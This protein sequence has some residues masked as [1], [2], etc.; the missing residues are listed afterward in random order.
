[1]NDLV[2]LAGGMATRLNNITQN[3]PKSLIEI[4]GKPF[5]DYQMELFK[6]KGIQNVIV[7]VGHFGEMIE[8]HVGDGSRFGL[9][10]KYSYDGTT[11][12]G[13]GG[14][15]RKALPLLNDAFFVMYGDSYFEVDF[16][17]IQT[18][19]KTHALPALM[20]V[21][22]NENQYDVSN[23]LFKDS[24]VLMYDKFKPTQEMTYIDYGLGLLSKAVFQAF[25]NQE[26]FD[27]AEV[28]SHLSKQKLLLGHEVHERFYE[29]GSISGIQAFQELIRGH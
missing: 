3:L 25:Q 6:R 15:I 2:L 19:F 22:K 1:M 23:V 10:V 13:T 5:I 4:E 8:H 9:S 29:I 27:L 21:Y 24:L 7:C 17:S 14:A 26:I 16:L 18:A 28:Y 11:L 12:L 20:T